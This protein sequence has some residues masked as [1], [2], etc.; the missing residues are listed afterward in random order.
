MSL[1]VILAHA[2]SCTCPSGPPCCSASLW[3]PGTSG[4]IGHVLTAQRTSE[5]PEPILS[6]W[7]PCCFS[8]PY[9]LLDVLWSARPLLLGGCLSV[10]WTL[11]FM[12]H[13]WC[14]PGHSPPSCTS[15]VTFSPLVNVGGT[16]VFFVY[17]WF[18]TQ[19]YSASPWPWHNTSGTSK[20]FLMHAY[21]NSTITTRKHINIRKS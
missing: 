14:P 7:L 21:C 16:C 4:Q 6:I 9:W 3:S 17:R 18:R 8:V 15:S 13:N 12:T 5:C 1:G 2:P 20:F 10:S 19:A 11:G